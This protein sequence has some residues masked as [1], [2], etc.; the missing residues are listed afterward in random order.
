MLTIGRARSF[1]SNVKVLTFGHS[2]GTTTAINI[3]V[4]MLA[5]PSKSFVLLE[6]KAAPLPCH[7]VCY[8]SSN[9]RQLLSQLGSQMCF[10]QQDTSSHCEAKLWNKW[11]CAEKLCFALGLPEK[12]VN[13]ATLPHNH[14]IFHLAGKQGCSRQKRNDASANIIMSQH[15]Q[16]SIF[17][18]AKFLPEGSLMRQG[19]VSS[20]IVQKKKL[21]SNIANTTVGFFFL[22]FILSLLKKEIV[23]WG[24]FR[25]V[26]PPFPSWICDK[27][28]VLCTELFPFS[29][30][31]SCRPWLVLSPGNP[32]G[33]FSLW[34][35]IKVHTK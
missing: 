24:W 27:I 32:T 16:N 10:G 23:L 25:L 26:P 6:R 2:Y 1:S 12:Q 20:E 29:A 34:T 3:T 14:S 35:C 15:L 30:K 11:Q 7:K 18:C 9:N 13:K 33:C 31:L 28:R 5:F 22:H 8:P 21:V 17:D 4:Q 19:T